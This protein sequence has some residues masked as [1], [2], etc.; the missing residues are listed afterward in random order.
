MGVGWRLP[1]R[2]VEG[3]PLSERTLPAGLLQ[4]CVCVCVCVCVRVCV[5]RQRA[6]DSAGGQACM[7][8]QKSKI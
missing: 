2:K 3:A 4:E 1:P 7:G 6:K 5:C 8:G